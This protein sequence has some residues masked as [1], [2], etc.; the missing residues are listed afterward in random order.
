MPHELVAFDPKDLAAQKD[1]LIQ[2]AADL[3]KKFPQDKIPY[4]P[5]K[6]GW[7]LRKGFE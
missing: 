4:D 3:L 5:K 1:T 2:K 7:N 6:F